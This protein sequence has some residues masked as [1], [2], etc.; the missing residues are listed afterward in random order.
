MTK[1]ALLLDISTINVSIPAIRVT[2]YLV[3]TTGILALAM[4]LA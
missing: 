3:V 4:A 1:L 2:I